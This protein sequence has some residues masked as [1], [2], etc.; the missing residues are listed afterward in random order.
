[1]IAL[2]AWA[3]A[4]EPMRGS[5]LAP[6]MVDAENA[7]ADMEEADVERAAVALEARIGCLTE[8]LSPEA[9]AGV[10]RLLGYRAFV[11]GDRANASAA[12]GAARATDPAWQMPDDL[13]PP[14][15]ALREV[16]TTA[17]LDTAT[18]GILVPPGTV[19]WVDAV[20]TNERSVD[21]P[22]FVQL[23]S[24]D[25][26]VLGSHWLLETD[27][28]PDWSALAS[29]VA[30]PAVL[31]QGK[32][33]QARSAVAWWVG[34][35]AALALGAGSYAWAVDDHRR[36][37]AL[38]SGLN[39]ADLAGLRTSANTKVGVAGGLGVIGIGLGVVAW[40]W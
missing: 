28:A 27:P 31:P 7:V 26:K 8:R 17:P 32:P 14:G 36:Y 3:W 29:T 5:D 21:R 24:L 25:G 16:F 38:D 19:L 2:V 4:C 11:R 15:T 37:V 10:H 35:A 23:L 12:F 18:E 13:A 33:Q 9:V 39:E 30:L 20:K 40:R 22:A 34:G 6:P 1:M